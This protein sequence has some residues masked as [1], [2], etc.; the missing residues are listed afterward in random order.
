MVAG[1]P[2][3]RRSA[4]GS[5]ASGNSR[6]GDSLREREREQLLVDD[7]RD[8]KRHVFHRV[9]ERRDIGRDNRLNRAR[10]R[11]LFLEPMRL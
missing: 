10:G 7:A 8:P 5:A 2:A 9:Q 11:E 3:A 6:P 4:R 1:H